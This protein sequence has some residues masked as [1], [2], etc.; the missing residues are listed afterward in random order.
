MVSETAMENIAALESEGLHISARDVIRLNAL[1]LRLE[2]T[3]DFRLASLPRIAV[4]G[5]VVLRQPT[6]AQDIFLDDAIQVMSADPATLLA[7]EAYVLSHPDEKFGKLK[8]PFWF[9]I[10]CKAWI[11]NH[12][13]NC[14]ATEVRRAVDYCLYGTDQK[15]GERPVYM[16]D[17]E[18]HFEL[19]DSPLSKAVRL[20]FSATS[21]GID[22]VA[23]LRAT[24]P[25]LEAM[26]ERAWLLNQLGAVSDAEKAA[27]AEYFATL[28]EIKRKAESA[29]DGKKAEVV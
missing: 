2:K 3:A 20:F 24:S 13:G 1:G 6:I 27:T 5:D 15:T 21:L 19:P 16:T 9:A 17:N 11:K 29:R 26:I 7:L 10:K 12:L 22:S 25:Q 18:D 8:H 14:L 23:A 28:D 4:L